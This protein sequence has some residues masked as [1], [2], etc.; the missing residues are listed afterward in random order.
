MH[1][2]C[3]CSYVNSLI[4]FLVLLQA[5]DIESRQYIGRIVDEQKQIV[6]DKADF[7]HCSST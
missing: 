5:I 1:I 6:L 2:T 4:P 7:T 3:H